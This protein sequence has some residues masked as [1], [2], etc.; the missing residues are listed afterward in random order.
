MK[1]QKFF[2]NSNNFRK[3]FSFIEIAVVILI[4][5]VTLIGVMQGRE[6][7]LKMRLNSARTL[8]ERSQVQN[9]ENLAL[10][11]E[12]TLEESLYLTSSDNASPKVLNDDQTIGRWNDLNFDKN[13]KVNLLQDT[14]AN[15]PKY[16]MNGINGLPALIFDGVN[17]FMQNQKQYFTNNFVLF[18]V[19]TPGRACTNLT[20]GN[21]GVSGQNYLIYPQYE[22]NPS[23]GFGVSLCKNQIVTAEN[24]VNYMP[25]RNTYTASINSP[26]L[27]NVV[28][29]NGAP[30]L[31][32]NSKFISTASASGYQIVPGYS[33]GRDFLTVAEPNSYGYFSGYVGEVIYYSSVLKEDDRKLIEAYLTEKWQIK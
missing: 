9:I 4:V 15:R 18:M 2:Q 11:L 6:L 10:W 17:D 24:S 5:A 29:N 21:V 31:Y 12:T 8:T 32:V 22:P 14:D 1:L 27:I 26:V 25:F 19:G 30:S 16:K 28:Y 13:L 33:I 3:A 7:Y 20:S 23:A